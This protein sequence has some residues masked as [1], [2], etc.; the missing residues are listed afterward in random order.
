MI[1]RQVASGAEQREGVVVSR[2]WSGA[3]R[4]QALFVAIGV[5][6]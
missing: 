6:S 4:Q 1:M 2:P 3:C 5:V